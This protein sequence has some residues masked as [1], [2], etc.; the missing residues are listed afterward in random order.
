VADEDVR[1]AE[2]AVSRRDGLDPESWRRA[3]RL[4]V[5]AAGAIAL[6]LAVA[7]S[8]DQR[9]GGLLLVVGWLVAIAA[10]HRLGRA[11]SSRRP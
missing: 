6:G 4:F 11:G 3:K 1:Q 2:P 5:A 8:V 7:G 10:L 9:V